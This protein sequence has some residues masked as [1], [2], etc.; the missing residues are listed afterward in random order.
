MKTH[1]ELWDVETGNL[2]GSYEQEE[3][4]LNMVRALV[5]ANGQEYVN[6]LELGCEDEQSGHFHAETGGSLLARVRVA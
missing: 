2:I 3:L 4:A 6:V 1:Y 5:E